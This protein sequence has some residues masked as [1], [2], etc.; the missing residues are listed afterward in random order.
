MQDCISRMQ[1]VHACVN[2]S[3]KRTNEDSTD[4]YGELVVED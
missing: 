3:V 1:L 2:H 4:V